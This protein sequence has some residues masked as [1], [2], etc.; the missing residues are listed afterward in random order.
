MMHIINRVEMSNR[1]S[2]QVKIIITLIFY[3]YFFNFSSGLYSLS[4]PSLSPTFGCH[5]MPVF[6]TFDLYTSNDVQM[7]NVNEMSLTSCDTEMPYENMPE[8][9]LIRYFTLKQRWHAH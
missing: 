7:S 2:V 6:V 4:S 5:S 3:I 9:E 1:T 8:R